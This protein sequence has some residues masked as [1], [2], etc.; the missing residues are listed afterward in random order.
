[1]FKKSIILGLLLFVVVVAFKL[2]IAGMSRVQFSDFKP[3]CA[4]FL[5]DVSASN[6]DLL[7]NQ[8]K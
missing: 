5:L 2:V 8:I 4:I 3:V 6:R 7:W 1:M